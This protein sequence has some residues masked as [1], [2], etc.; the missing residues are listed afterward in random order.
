MVRMPEEDE[1]RTD[2]GPGTGK[3]GE[4]I[5]ASPFALFA[6]LKGPAVAM[7]Y[8]DPTKRVYTFSL[9]CNSTLCHVD[10]DLHP[11]YFQCYDEV[12]A[13]D[14]P[15]GAPQGVLKFQTVL[16]SS[17]TVASVDADQ[18]VG[19]GVMKAHVGVK[20]QH[21]WSTPSALGIVHRRVFF[22]PSSSLP[23]IR[24]LSSTAPAKL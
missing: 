4:C 3:A 18:E 24:S 23:S 20:S 1:G 5:C 22:R 17:W 9:P 2:R 12:L 19:Q 8:Q 16:I 21:A 11:V 10:Q 14:A 7:L 13:T 6:R 15:Q